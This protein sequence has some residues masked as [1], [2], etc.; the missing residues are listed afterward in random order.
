VSDAFRNPRFASERLLMRPQTK[1]DAEALHEAYRDVALMTWWSSA[2]H[3]S[4]EETRAYLWDATMPSEWRGWVMVERD[5]G[6]VVGTLAAGTGRKPKVTE[7]G[8]M[9]IRR[10][11]G[12][13]FAREG[14]GRL[15]DLLFE[16]EGDRRVWADTDPDNAASN[17]LLEALG[18]TLEGRLRGEWETHIGVRDSLIWGLLRDEWPNS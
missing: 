2:P 13:G 5:T 7:I 4:V 10:F 18:F 12:R 6:A 1:D 17:R 15:I 3:A 9:L 11:W 8:Y 14:V 16:E